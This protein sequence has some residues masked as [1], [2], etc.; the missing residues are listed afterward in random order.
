[1]FAQSSRKG[2]LPTLYAAVAAN[3]A[4]NTYV[5]PSGMGEL[6]GSPQPNSFKSALAQDQDL[7]CT[8]WETSE[9]LTGVVFEL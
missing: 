4:A 6:W 8:L 1:L 9:Q 3:L 7:A 5:G 2:A